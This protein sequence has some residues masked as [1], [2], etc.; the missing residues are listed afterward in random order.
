MR[1]DLVTVFLL[2]AGSIAGAAAAG[3][4]ECLEGRAASLQDEALSRK[5]NL[6][7]TN[8]A[9]S[10]VFDLVGKATGLQ[11]DASALGGRKIDVNIKDMPARQVLEFFER[12]LRAR[13]RQDG[14]KIFV[15]KTCT[16]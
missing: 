4:S 3:T 14:K 13:Y 11:F 12:E 6:V 2:V 5:V 15:A 8:V 1:S 16:P 10:R 7:A 9:A